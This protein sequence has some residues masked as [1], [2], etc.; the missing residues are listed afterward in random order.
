MQKPVHTAVATGILALLA[1]QSLMAV[2]FFHDP[3]DGTSLDPRWTQDIS[4]ASDANAPDG[5][6]VIVADGQARAQT[7]QEA[8]NHLETPIDTD[9]E[10]AVEARTLVSSGMGTGAHTLAV[11]WDPITY[12]YLQWGNQN[13][14]VRR[15]SDPNGYHNIFLPDHF[16]GPGTWSTLRMEFWD[17]TIKFFAM[18]TGDPNFRDVSVLDIPRNA[19]FKQPV[20][21]LI[22]GKGKQTPDATEPD[23]DNDESEVWNLDNL[24][25]DYITYE[26]VGLWKCGAEGT[27]YLDGDVTE[28]CYVE[29]ADVSK[30]GDQ[31]LLCTDGANAAC[32][33]IEAFVDDFPG[34]T[35]HPRW[36]DDNS[37]R[38]P[39]GPYPGGSDFS[40]PWGPGLMIS[41]CYQ[42]SYHHIETPIDTTGNF[43]VRARLNS[44]LAMGHGAPRTAVYW[45]QTH[46]VSLAA[47]DAGGIPVERE[48]YDGSS[49]T[50][51]DHPS[52]NGSDGGYYTMLIEFTPTQVLFSIGGRDTTGD[53]P[54]YEPTWDL[55]REPWMT[56]TALFIM[57]KGTGDPALGSNPDFDN[58]PYPYA[59]GIRAVIITDAAYQPDFMPRPHS[60]G[61][62][63]TWYLQADANNDCYVNLGDFGDIA[64]Q[65]FWCS[66]PVN[67]QCDVYW[68][69]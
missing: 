50:K 30:L 3:F 62:I 55:P 51:L 6:A 22:D 39:P 23:F 17:D 48:Y 47:R 10:F 31:W 40:F 13:Y 46:F 29:M 68:L 25:F 32:D 69:D 5:G 24:W 16:M 65:W 49:F 42:E 1:C 38:N 34:P 36:F 44:Q 60:C 53:I 43:E 26:G 18:K 12:V 63:G 67:P 8:Y 11:Y 21:L 35:L 58:E 2:D 37:P 20:G 61:D 59:A 33:R 27:V 56:G 45:D 9:G 64:R 15:W 41:Q 19:A 52:Q 54:I 57:G 28:D 14:L 4:P 7:Y 66:D